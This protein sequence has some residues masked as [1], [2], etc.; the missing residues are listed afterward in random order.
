M[1][2]LF[3]CAEHEVFYSSHRD[4]DRATKFDVTLQSNI[5]HKA[6]QPL[7]AGVA[8]RIIFC[9]SSLTTIITLRFSF[10]IDFQRNT[11]FEDNYLRF[12][13]STVSFQFKQNLLGNYLFEIVPLSM[14]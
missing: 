6:H 13:V 11:Y 5:R 10:I 3:P 1:A 9:V 14:I 8:Y 4:N 7:E 12:C 2:G